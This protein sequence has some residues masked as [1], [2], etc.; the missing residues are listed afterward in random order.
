MEKEL[1]LTVTLTADKEQLEK[2]L[3]TQKQISKTT[4][5]QLQEMTQKYE[6]EHTMRIEL[7]ESNHRLEHEL[8][9]LQRE[10]IKNGEMLS[11]EVRTLSSKLS[12]ERSR[13][14]QTEMEKARLDSSLQL[15]SQTSKQEQKKL[16]MEIQNVNQILLEEK[17][18]RDESEKKLSHQ[19]KQSETKLKE[20][21]DENVHLKLHIQSLEKQLAEFK[22][23]LVQLLKLLEIKKARQRYHKNKIFHFDTTISYRSLEALATTFTLESIQ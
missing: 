19:L 22:D 20:I 15:L 8:A 3:M 9:Q 2:E 11:E 5:D 10:H 13:R 18:Q 1:Q 6:A 7:E 14:H 21:T 16:E 4:A 17:Q 23:Q 12:A